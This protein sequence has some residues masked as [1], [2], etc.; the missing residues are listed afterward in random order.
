MIQ[1]VRDPFPVSGP[2]RLRP[3]IR[4][5]PTCRDRAMWLSWAPAGGSARRFWGDGAV[6]ALAV[7]SKTYSFLALQM[8]RTTNFAYTNDSFHLSCTIGLNQR[9]G[10]RPSIC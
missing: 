3:G 8:T 1:L 10:G 6:Q 7:L 5:R 4:R 9:A 2:L